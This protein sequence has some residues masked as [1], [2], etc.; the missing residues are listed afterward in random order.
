[1]GSLIQSFETLNQ[2]SGISFSLT[3]S[4][5]FVFLLICGILLF[6]K[7]IKISYNYRLLLAML[8]F[9][10]GIIAI[11]QAFYTQLIQSDLGTVTIFEKGIDT[12]SQRLSFEDIKDAYIYTDQQKS[13]VNPEQTIKSEKV[14]IIEYGDNK[15]LRLHENDYEVE[16]IFAL[17]RKMVN[18]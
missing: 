5:G 9:F 7:R 11:G 2:D 12:P 15:Q 10:F 3:A 4:I 6:Y 16:A 8:A 17:M 14:L 13:I 18:Q 1:M